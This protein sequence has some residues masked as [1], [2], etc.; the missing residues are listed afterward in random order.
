MLPTRKKRSSLDKRLARGRSAGQLYE[1]VAFDER[2]LVSD[3]YGNVQGGFAQVLSCRAGFIYLRGSEA[4]IASRLE[5]R[6]PMV[7]R[8]RATPET[9]QIGPDWQMRDLKNGAWTDS[10][11]TVWTGPIYAVRSIAETEDR[12]WLDIMVE[13]GVAA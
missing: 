13:R 5:G 4:V 12:R 1:R 9:R 7:V 11:E 3:G 10:S 8:V 6:Q 2:Q